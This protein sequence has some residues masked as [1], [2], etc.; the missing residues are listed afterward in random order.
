MANPGA[1]PTGISSPA[2][3]VRYGLTHAQRIAVSHRRPLT[4]RALAE[5]YDRAIVDEICA[6]CDRLAARAA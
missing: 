1:K 5:R 2:A 6:L 4:M 3:I